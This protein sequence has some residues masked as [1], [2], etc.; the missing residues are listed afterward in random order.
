M[1]AR[2]SAVIDL[3]RRLS[4]ER[5][6]V[7][8]CPTKNRRTGRRCEYTLVEAWTSSECVTRRRCK[9]CGVWYRVRLTADG[10]ASALPE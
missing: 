9:Q 7:V 10:E 2:G 6:T 3:E 5:L 4:T 1:H 8:P